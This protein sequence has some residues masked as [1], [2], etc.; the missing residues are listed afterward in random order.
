M[1]I[2]IT[3]CTVHHLALTNVANTNPIIIDRSNAQID[4]GAVYNKPDNL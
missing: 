2:T 3:E 4:F 1:G